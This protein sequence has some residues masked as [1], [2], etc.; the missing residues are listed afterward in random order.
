MRARL[1]G[2]PGSHP[3]VSAEL[4]LRHKGIEYTRVDLPNITHRA[5]LPLMR[6]RGFTVPVINLDGRKVSGTMRIA[7]ARNSRVAPGSDSR[8]R[9]DR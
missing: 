2:V 6:Y 1:I 5:I 3:A 8:R 4:M 9:I 7:L